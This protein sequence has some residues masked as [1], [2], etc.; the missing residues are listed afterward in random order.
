LLGGGPAGEQHVLEQRAQ[1][2]A[3]AVRALADGFRG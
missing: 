1:L 2:E 3:A